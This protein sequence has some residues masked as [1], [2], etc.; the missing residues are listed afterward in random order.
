MKKR[1]FAEASSAD[2]RAMEADLCD[3]MRIAQVA[4]KYK[5][6]VDAVKLWWKKKC[7]DRKIDTLVGELHDVSLDDD[8]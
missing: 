5:T 7:V 2:V 6:D 1:L 4:K 8:T 3:G